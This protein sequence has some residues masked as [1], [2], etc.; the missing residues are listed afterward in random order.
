MFRDGCTAYV[1]PVCCR[2]RWDS[3]SSRRVDKQYTRTPRLS[4]RASSGSHVIFFVVSIRYHRAHFS[5]LA[6]QVFQSWSLRVLPEQLARS[7]LSMLAACFGSSPVA[8]APRLLRTATVLMILCIG[9]S[10]TTTQLRIGHETHPLFVIHASHTYILHIPTDTYIHHL[11]RA[12]NS[13][14]PKSF[15]ATLPNLPNQDTRM[16][17]DLTP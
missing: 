16:E 10:T 17:T 12:G 6:R 1:V 5:S 15:L 9:I 7:K 3:V 8:H 2:R 14:R 13:K 11:R 4:G